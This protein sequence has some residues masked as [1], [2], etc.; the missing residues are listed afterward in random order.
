VQYDPNALQPHQLR[1]TPARP[2]ASQPPVERLVVTFQRSHS[3]DA[4]RRRLSDL[5]DLLEKY[6]GTDRFVILVEATGQPRYQL[7]FPN[8]Y[9]RICKDLTNEL[10]LRLGPKRWYLE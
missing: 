9:T 8:S 2:P 6:K 3:L 1:E 5:V 10:G 4:D 7:E